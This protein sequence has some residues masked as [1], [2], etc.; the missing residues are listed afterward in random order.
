[1]RTGILF[2]GRQPAAEAR[3]KNWTASRKQNLRLATALYNQSLNTIRASKIPYLHIDN[4]QQNGRNFNEK[5]TKAL[6]DF[7]D[8][9]MDHAIVVGSDCGDL[10]VSDLQRA[11]EAIAEGKNVTG[12]TYDGGLYLFTLSK[13]DF[14]VYQLT[15]LPW[16]SA[17]LGKAFI[18]L[19]TSISG[20]EM[21]HLPKRVD[22][23]AD[24]WAVRSA[25]G[26]SFSKLKQWI[27][28]LLSIPTI[29]TCNFTFSITFFLSLSPLRGPPTN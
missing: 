6:S 2:F 17:D 13:K 21:I 28:T 22:V 29:V 19:V 14:D 18:E 12:A 20:N 3:A 4:E 10:Q 25:A 16:C 23:D 5:I 7:F 15:A 27:N 24:L 26:F 8:S 11:A 1:M 9:G